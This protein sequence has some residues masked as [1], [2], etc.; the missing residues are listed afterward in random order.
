M[1]S[2]A[3]TSTPMDIVA[4]LSLATGTQYCIQCSGDFEAE[5]HEDL[6]N[7]LVAGTVRAAAGPRPMRLAPRSQTPLRYRV[8]ADTPLWCWAP[9]LPAAVAVVRAP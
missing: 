2:L 9:G 5:I 3:V 7:A 4:R 1:A 6:T 8:R